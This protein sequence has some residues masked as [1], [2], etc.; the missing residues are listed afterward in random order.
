MGPDG[1]FAQVDFAQMYL[2]QINRHAQERE[3]QNARNNELIQSGTVSALDLEAPN[4]AVEE[5]NRAT[6]LM[7][8]QQSKEAVKHL[9][10]AISVYPKLSPPHWPWTRLPRSRGWGSRSGR[11]RSSR[12]ARCKISRIVPESRALALSRNDFCDRPARTGESRFPSAQRSQ[13]SILI[14]L[15][16]K[17]NS[18][19]SRSSGNCPARARAQPQRNGQ[20]ALRGRVSSHV[21]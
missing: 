18:S 10:K 3:Q 19:I 5:F 1:G 14:G 8:A 4:K 9:Q 2:D 17:W 6:S 7:K 20:C 15:C 12:Q 16:A 21:S 13:N 11:V